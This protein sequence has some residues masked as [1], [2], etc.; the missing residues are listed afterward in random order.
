[1]KAEIIMKVI[2]A[3]I[4][5]LAFLFGKYVIPKFA[6]SQDLTYLIE[7]VNKLVLSA[8][9]IYKDNQGKEKLEYVTAALKEIC[10]KAHIEITDEQ[11]RALIE[12]AYNTMKQAEKEGK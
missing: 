5:V 4:L 8:K 12:E 1:M 9:N 3:V 7:W 2:E 6:N 10:N 11:I